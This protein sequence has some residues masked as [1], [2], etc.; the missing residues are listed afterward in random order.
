MRFRTIFWPAVGLVL[1][2]AIGWAFWPRPVLVD[3]AEVERGEMAVTVR[4]EGFTRVREVYVVSAPV[5]GRLLRVEAEAG[6]PVEAAQLLA[7]ILP[8]DPAFLDA[9]TQSEFQAAFRTA[10]AALGFAVAERR[11][12]EAQAE[13]AISEAERMEALFERGTIGQAQLDRARLERRTAEASLSTAQA[14]VRMRI[15]ERDAAQARLIEPG[16]DVAAAGVVEIASPIDGRVLRVLQES[17]AVVAAGSP[18]LEIGDPADLE[19][20]AELLSTDAVQIRE[21][22]PA[23]IEHWGGPQALRA[24]VRRVEPYGFLKISALGVEEQRVNVILDF[25]DPPEVWAGLGHGFRV[26]PAIETW[27]GEDVVIAPAAALF[28]HEGGW[29]AFIA[30]GGRAELRTVEIGR[31]NGIQAEVTGGLAAGDRLI[32]HPPDAVADG[33]AVRPREG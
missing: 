31:T 26:E 4:D 30:V 8:S 3:F 16:E 23:L 33:V 27:R 11:R 14:T 19:I 18:L 21:G 2:L 9:R 6:D 5:G 20:V 32:L 1:V 7:N 29:A 22:A 12:A 25:V 28:R 13:Y 15:A 17:E 10:E 24:R